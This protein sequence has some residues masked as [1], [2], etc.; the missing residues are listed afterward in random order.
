MRHHGTW[1]IQGSLGTR[2]IFVAKWA[3]KIIKPNE[4]HCQDGWH[5]WQAEKRE[6]EDESARSLLNIFGLHVLE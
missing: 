1:I 2:C 5:G 4:S 3:S 6:H